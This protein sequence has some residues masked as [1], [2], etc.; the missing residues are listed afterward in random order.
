MQRPVPKTKTIEPIQQ[1][2]E[3]AVKPLKMGL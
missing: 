2:D 1:N 3:A